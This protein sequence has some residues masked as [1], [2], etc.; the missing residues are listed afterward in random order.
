MASLV[1]AFERAGARCEVS[2][3]RDAYRRAELLV[4][5]GVGAAPDARR[6]LDAA[7]LVPR[8]RDERRPVLGICLGMQL[9]FQSSAEGEV[10][11]LGV[12]AGRV[13]RLRA[14]AGRPVP[15]SGW[16]RLRPLARSRLLDGDSGDSWFYF[17][18]SY[19]APVQRDT[20]AAAAHAAPFAAVVERAPFYGTQ[21]HPERSGPAGATLLA[22]FLEL[23][24]CA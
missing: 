16:S 8:L 9:L 6:R 17:V 14:E 18:H 24:R 20:V 19:A 1:D 23:E 3:E 15:N 7:G 21:F 13:E 10:E 2:G 11:G 5:P 22:R 12:V 4:L